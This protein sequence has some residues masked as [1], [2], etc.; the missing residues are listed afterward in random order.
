MG[1]DVEITWDHKRG[2]YSI[3][4]AILLYK[5]NF[6]LEDQPLTNVALEVSKIVSLLNFINKHGEV[7]IK[8]LETL[9]KAHSERKDEFVTKFAEKNIK[10]YH[11]LRNTAL[12]RI[13]KQIFLSIVK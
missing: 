2:I 5:S 11:S 6:K 4:N 9:V 1:D 13:L 7:A 10:L 12:E 3:K 8:E